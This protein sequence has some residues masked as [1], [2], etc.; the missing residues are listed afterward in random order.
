MSHINLTRLTIGIMIIVGL[1]F[2]KPLAYFVGIMM[3]FAGLTG[4]CL[5]EM[6]YSK[7]FGVSSSCS[8]MPAG[9]IGRPKKIGVI[10][11]SNDAETCWNAFRFA[12]FCLNSKDEVKIFLLGKGV[13]YQQISSAEFNIVEQAEKLL[14]AGGKVFACGTCIK[15]RQQKE[16]NLCPISTMQDMYRIV[17]ESDKVVTF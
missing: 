5:L 4:I 10:I 9:S 7:V 15:S 16:S 6:F 14:G 8:V 3:I 2:F 12:N 1:L 17:S 13:E 11:S